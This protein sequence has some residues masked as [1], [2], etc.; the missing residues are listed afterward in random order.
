VKFCISVTFFAVNLHAIEIYPTCLRQTGLSF[1]AVLG[2]LLG[3]LG[4]YIV[5]VGQDVDLRFPFYVIGLM[6][7]SGC[8]ACLF[9]PETLHQN[10]P[11]TLEEATKFGKHQVKYLCKLYFCVEN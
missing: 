3:I 4:P 9:L 6:A 7:L 8:V 2:N 10:L 1:G 11:E 5:K